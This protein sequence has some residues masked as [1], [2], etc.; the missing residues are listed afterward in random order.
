MRTANFEFSCDVYR[1]GVYRVAWLYWT[2]KDSQTGRIRSL[3]KITWLLY[4]DN[5]IALNI[6][7]KHKH[8]TIWKP[9]LFLTFNAKLM[10]CV[11][12]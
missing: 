7:G 3:K 11:I 1:E 2:K 12:I 6:V 9:H 10:Q 4:F 5:T 8:H